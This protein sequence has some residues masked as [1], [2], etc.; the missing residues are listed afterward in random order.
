MIASD[1]EIINMPDVNEAW[2]RMLKSDVK[3]RFLKNI[4]S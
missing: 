1:M 2:K 4:T 3:N